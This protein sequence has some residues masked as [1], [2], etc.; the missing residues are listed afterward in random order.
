M[1][2][3]NKGDF[4]QQGVNGHVNA[5]V[6]LNEKRLINIDLTSNEEAEGCTI[7]GQITDLLN[8]TTYSLAG[9]PSGPDFVIPEQ[10]VSTPASGY[11]AVEGVDLGDLQ[12]NDLVIVHMEGNAYGTEIDGYRS[13]RLSQDNP[14]DPMYMSFVTPFTLEGVTF[15]IQLDVIESAAG[16]NWG[17]RITVNNVQTLFENITLSAIAGF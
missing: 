11:V 14:G 7:S 8:N 10:T 6:R 17:A 9:G 1:P 4:T 5:T 12:L 16:D 15:T 2:D 13:G 3:F